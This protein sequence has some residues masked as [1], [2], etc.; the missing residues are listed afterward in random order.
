MDGFQIKISAQ[1]LSRAKQIKP[2]HDPMIFDVSC[3]ANGKFSAL[4]ARGS[5]RDFVEQSSDQIV[6]YGEI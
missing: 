2:L 4:N 5:S 1:R 3:V 6:E